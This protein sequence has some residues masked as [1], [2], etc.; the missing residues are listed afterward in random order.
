MLSDTGREAPIDAT[1]FY[2]RAGWT[3]AA[4]ETYRARFGNFGK[5]IHA[6]PDSFRR[7]EDGEEIT[8]GAHRWRVVVGT[9]HSPEHACLF[10]PELAVMISGDQLL[11]K[12]SS[13]VSVHPTEP[14]ADP[15]G[16]WLSSLAKLRQAVPEHTLVLPAH[17]E[18]FK[19]AHA[20]IDALVAG[21]ERAMQRLRERLAEP[22]R[23]TELFVALF[24]RPIAET[25]SL[26]LN[27]ATG[28]TIACLNYLLHR[29]EARVAAG[30]GGVSVYR[31]AS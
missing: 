28:E 4:I 15:M 12:I 14:E 20:R 31:L 26:H 16:D 18:C 17:N 22:K 11:P 8:I 30:E 7:M 24:G 3:D 25:D 13:N 2:Q 1:T 23:V 6:L 21:Q 29:G 5:H 19:G 10:C 9:G 27:L